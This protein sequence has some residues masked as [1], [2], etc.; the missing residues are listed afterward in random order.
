MKIKALLFLLF[1]FLWSTSLNAQLRKAT[2]DSIPSSVLN[3]AKILAF[4]SF[5]FQKDKNLSKFLMEHA[6]MHLN[7]VYDMKKNNEYCELVYK[8]YGKLKKV[9]LQ[10]VLANNNSNYIFRFKGYYEGDDISEIR[11][12]TN[13]LFKFSGFSFNGFYYDKF[14]INPDEVP[15]KKLNIDTLSKK[16]LDRAYQLVEKSLRC[17]PENYPKL[18]LEN[19]TP[20]MVSMFTQKLLTENCVKTYK[21]F[22]YMVSVKLAEVLGDG[23]RT[24]YRYKVEYELLE[25]FIE[26]TVITNSENKF[27]MMFIVPEWNDTFKDYKNK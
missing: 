12:A 26:V 8:S 23:Y 25:N 5:K 18:T 1:C 4:D 7:K 16:N 20:Q 24:I 2:L 17:R 21:N 11:L 10:E 13:S 27:R 3:N 9:I 15:L 6:N 22:G 19:A 14:Y